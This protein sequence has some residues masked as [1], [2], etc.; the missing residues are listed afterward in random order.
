MTRLATDSD[1][2]H[3]K[4]E[5]RK[6]DIKVLHLEVARANMKAR[7]LYSQ[8]GFSAREKYVLMSIPL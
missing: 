8:A 6:F 7:Q 3:I 4:A 2:P 1:L 5:A